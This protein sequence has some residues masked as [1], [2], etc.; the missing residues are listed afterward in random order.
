MGKYDYSSA[1]SGAVTG[2]S[3]G[4]FGGPVG[5]GVGAL[6]GGIAGLFGSKKKKTKKPKR[7]S[8][9]SPEQEA[10]HRDTINSLRGQGPFS[11]LYNYNADAANSN[12]EQNVAQP[13]YRNFNENIIPS[14]TG[15]FRSNNIGNSSYTGEAL[16]RHGRDIQES[17][18]AARSNMHMQGQQQANQNKISGIQNATNTQTFAYSKPGAQ[19]PNMMDQILGSVGPEAAKWLLDYMK[20]SP[21]TN[22]PSP[23]G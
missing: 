18:N 9:M 23:V 12:F 11:D 3:L 17:L 8:T 4:S 7:L 5:M 15:Q 22:T 21:G 16:S 13:A 2:A 6:V 1:A 10:L 19:N 14:V 20:S